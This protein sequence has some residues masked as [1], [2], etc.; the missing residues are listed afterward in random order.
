VGHH[1]LADG[2]YCASGQRGVLDLFRREENKEGQEGEEE[3]EVFSSR[4]HRS[5]K[6]PYHLGQK[7][8]KIRATRV[9]KP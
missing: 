2:D 4:S 7:C 1:G 8:Y 9:S 3:E 5:L 6:L